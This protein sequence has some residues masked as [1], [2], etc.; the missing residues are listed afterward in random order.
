MNNLIM[1]VLKSF[2][3]WKE[4][5]QENPLAFKILVFLCILLII[6]AFLYDAYQKRE[7]I[8]NLDAESERIDKEMG[9]V[10]NAN[11]N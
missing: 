3:Y 8:P 7:T 10:K 6:L 1:G 5:A 11:I 4:A 9:E 2:N